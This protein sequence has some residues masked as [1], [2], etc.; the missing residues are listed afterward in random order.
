MLDVN[1][2]NFWCFLFFLSIFSLGYDSALGFVEAIST[3]IYDMR[4]TK[5]S[6]LV[7]NKQLRMVNA[8]FICL[9]GFACSLPF[10]LNSGLIWLNIFDHFSAIYL[11]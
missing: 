9:I 5:D 1:G 11:M 6:G 7:N 8:G 4:F 2:S 10:C 3:A